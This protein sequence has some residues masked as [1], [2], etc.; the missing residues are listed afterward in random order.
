MMPANAP[1]RRTVWPLPAGLDTAVA[2]DWETRNWRGLAKSAAA[3]AAHAS[4]L[5]HGAIGHVMMGD[6]KTAIALLEAA[7]SRD[8]PLWSIAARIE[9]YLLDARNPARQALLEHASASEPDDPML[10]ARLLHAHGVHALQDLRWE[11]S[12]GAL[13]EA[14]RQFGSLLS[15]AGAA[16][17]AD[18]LG[19]ALLASGRPDLAQLALTRALARKMVLDDGPGTAITLG[20]LGRCALVQGRWQEAIEYFALD[21]DLVRVSGAST[22]FLETW[23]AYAEIEAGRAADAAT[24]LE[25]LRA[26]A[27]TQFG[28]AP[29]SMIHL[30]RA[31]TRLDRHNQARTLLE[32]ISSADLPVH[33]RLW[34]GIAQ[35]EACGQTP[36]A[37]QSLALLAEEAELH[38]LVDVELKALRA[39]IEIKGDTESEHRHLKRAIRLASESGYAAESEWLR[40]RLFATPI[41]MMVANEGTDFSLVEGESLGRRFLIRRRLGGGQFGTVFQAY[42]LR[43]QCDVA[44]K[45]LGFPGNQSS[46][47]IRERINS[48]KSELEAAAVLHHPGLARVYGV[49]WADSRKPFIVQEWI[50][51]ATLRDRLPWKGTRAELLRFMADITGTLTALHSKGIVHRDLKPENILVREDDGGPVLID[52]GIAC[53]SQSTDDHAGFGTAPYAAPEQARGARVTPA[54][55]AY[56]LGVMLTEVTG[57]RAGEP[58]GLLGRLRNL[59]FKSRP[60]AWSLA[61]LIRQLTLPDVSQRLGDLNVARYRLLALAD[62]E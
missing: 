10:R 29:F 1:S 61:E 38:G 43:R 25:S 51:G 16:Q 45:V 41:T 9:L 48:L 21:L 32:T 52:L 60:P 35:A 55:D 62:V 23:I 42:D 54:A 8:D 34:L 11:Q 50:R 3:S 7:T 19:G 4:V 15:L 13:S 30:A 36:D 46:V 27:A 59:G 44:L 2:D 5:V 33:T 14:E 6:R 28:A 20:N 57:V 26:D 17:V 24:R 31:W 22:L 40:A 58:V 39:C 47:D 53:L 18:T 56:A 12:L 49:G 37:R